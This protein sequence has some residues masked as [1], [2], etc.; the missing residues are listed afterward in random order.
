MRFDWKNLTRDDAR[1]IARKKGL[2]ESIIKL[3]DNN[4]SDISWFIWNSYNQDDLVLPNVD[5]GQGNSN[6]W[7][8][9]HKDFNHYNN[10]ISN[11]IK[12]KREKHLSLHHKGKIIPDEQVKKRIHTLENKS[13]KEKEEFKKK[14]RQIKANRSDEEKL[15]TL[16]KFRQTIER[17]SPKQ[18]SERSRRGWE[19]RRQRY[20]SEKILEKSRE[21]SRKGWRTKRRNKLIRNLIHDMTLRLVKEVSNEFRT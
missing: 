20:S 6:E 16:E 12:I 17:V 15:I 3:L 19:T 13:D 14:Q 1:K 8:I 21:L 4:G 9:H 2:V 11:L 18:R 5:S 7:N 10:D